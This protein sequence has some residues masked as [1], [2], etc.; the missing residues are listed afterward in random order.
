MKSLRLRLHPDDEQMHPMHAFVVEH[1]AFEQ[2]RLLHWNPAVSE[3]NT[4][5]F[6]VVGTDVEAYRDALDASPSV[7]SYEVVPTGGETFYL[8]VQDRLD[9]TAAEQTTAFTQDGLVV[10]PPVVFDGDGSIQVT[11]VGTTTALQSAVDETPDGID[12]E[13]LQ[14][15]QYAG[16]TELSAPA[17][18]RRQREAVDEAVACGYYREPREG[19]VSE[20]ADRLGC[21]AGTAA[22]HLRKAEM[23]VMSAV[24]DER[25][26]D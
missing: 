19:T 26:V 18:S 24:A 15:R 8:S 9:V 10:V 17:L 6:E 21:S 14:I 23:K 12:V 22:E 25:G 16:E 20:V 13:V 2:T 5:I 1:E 7:L 11:V 3:V 4:I